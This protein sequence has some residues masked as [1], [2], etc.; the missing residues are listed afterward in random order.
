MNIRK[1][2]DYNPELEL[3]VAQIGI[4]KWDWVDIDGERIQ[5]AKEKMKSN[6]FDI[7]P[8]SENGVCSSYFKT[9]EW[10]NFNTGILPATVPLKAPP[11]SSP[12]KTALPVAC[13]FEA[14][15]HEAEKLP[16]FMSRLL[17]PF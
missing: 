14:I 16:P 9:K 2:F 6:R 17:L 4:N 12:T 10:G 7:L 1:Y 11:V 15:I 8:I 3:T 5:E 13:K